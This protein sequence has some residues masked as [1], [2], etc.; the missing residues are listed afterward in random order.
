MILKNNISNV[1]IKSNSVIPLDGV[2]DSSPFLSGGGALFVYSALIASY[3]ADE[4][5]KEILEIDGNTITAFEGSRYDYE[6][7][8]PDGDYSTADEIL[9]ILLGGDPE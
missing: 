9:A 2:E 5:W 7:K 3:N 6:D 1:C 8:Y 4:K